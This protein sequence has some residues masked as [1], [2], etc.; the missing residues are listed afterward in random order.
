M[1]EIAA[2][3]LAIMATIQQTSQKRRA[4]G[5]SDDAVCKKAQLVEKFSCTG[6]WMLCGRGSGRS[7]HFCDSTICDER[8]PALDLT[9]SHLPDCQ[10][11]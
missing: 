4:D 2:V 11:S 9:C 5:V 10:A 7:W 3:A 8:E 6:K 1:Q